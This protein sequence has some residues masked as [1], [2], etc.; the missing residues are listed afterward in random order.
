MH[1]RGGL[2]LQ[3]IHRSSCPRCFQLKTHINLCSNIDTKK[4]ARSLIS[5][6]AHSALT[7]PA[8][9]PVQAGAQ[10]ANSC[11]ETRQLLSLILFSFLWA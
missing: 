9:R 6:A 1:E 4:N 8:Q 7:S 10:K 3:K 2:H 5:A 11:Y